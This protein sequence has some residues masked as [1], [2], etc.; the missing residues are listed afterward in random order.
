MALQIQNLTRVFK[1][2]EEEDDDKSLPDP[3]PAFSAEEVMEFY[4][5]LHPELTTARIIGPTVEDG[6]AVFNFVTNYGV[7][8]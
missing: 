8:G 1:F 4:A 7:K 5:G 6:K 2:N 3:N